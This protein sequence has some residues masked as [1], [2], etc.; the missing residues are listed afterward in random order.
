[1]T[2]TEG[3]SQPGTYYRSK[4]KNLEQIAMMTT[5]MEI[6]ITTAALFCRCHCCRS[7]IGC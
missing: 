3:D 7:C 6:V 4:K 2:I 1:M 5:T